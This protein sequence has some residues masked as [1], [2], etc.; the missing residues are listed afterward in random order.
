M[1]IGGHRY[2]R[3]EKQKDRETGGERQGDMETRGT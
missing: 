3:I 2:R 1:D